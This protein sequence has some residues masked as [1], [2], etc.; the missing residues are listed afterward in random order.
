VIIVRFVVIIEENGVNYSDIVVIIQ[1]NVVIAI[2]FGVFKR[3]RRVII[4]FFDC[5]ATEDEV[6]ETI[7]GE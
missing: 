1:E 7:P 6:Y 3:R 5:M 4:S 2:D